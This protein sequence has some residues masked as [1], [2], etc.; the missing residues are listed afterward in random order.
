[1]NRDLVDHLPRLHSV[2]LEDT[3]LMGH[4]KFAAKIIKAPGL[5]FHLGHRPEFLVLPLDEK[6][7]RG[8][9]IPPVTM[10]SQR[11]DTAIK[12]V[13]LIEKRQRAAR[14]DLEN[15]RVGGR[16]PDVMMVVLEHPAEGDVRPENRLG[17]KIHRV[18]LLIDQKHPLFQQQKNKAI[19]QMQE[20]AYL[21]TV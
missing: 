6:T 15:I 2:K 4:V 16:Q 1:M 13:V 10:P 20:T 14:Y 19:V 7:L 8:A 9:Y 11:K 18:A 3:R 21:G 5:A 17:N 12:A